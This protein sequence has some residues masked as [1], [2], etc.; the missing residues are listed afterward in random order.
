MSE[1]ADRP[2][3]AG[4]RAVRIQWPGKILFPGHWGAPEHTEGGLADHDPPGLD[5]PLHAESHP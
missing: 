1:D 3:R 4:R 5:G 2:I